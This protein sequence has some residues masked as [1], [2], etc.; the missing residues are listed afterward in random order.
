MTFQRARSAEQ[1]EERRRTILDTARKMLDEMPVAEV[2]LNELSRRVGL[3][4]SNVLRYFESREAVLLELLDSALHDW[5]AEATGEVAEG[6]DPDRPARE[7]AEAFAAVVSRS[8][9]RHTVL[10]DLIGAQAGVLEHNVSTDVV[11]RFKRSALGSLDTMA[12]LLRSAVPEV[13][14]S[15][16]SVCLLGMILA[17]SLQTHC[18]PSP[19]ALAAYAA[20][21]ALA[22]LHLDLAPAL[23][24]GLTL[25]ITG[26][27]AAQMP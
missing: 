9:A 5:L 14:D 17:G 19:S 27:M 18:R 16:A 10:C 12:G 4:K 22:A 3:A 6:V 24:Q 26:A 20:D 8:L 2:S 13:G 7:R 11:V 21:P 25:L 23:T 1:R 15:A